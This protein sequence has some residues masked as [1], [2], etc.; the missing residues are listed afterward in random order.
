MYPQRLIEDATVSGFQSLESIKDKIKTFMWETTY[1]D[2]F[3]DWSNR[4]HPVTG[5]EI[6]RIK[7]FKYIIEVY[8]TDEPATY[9]VSIHTP[10]VTI[11]YGGSLW[12]N[13][14][15]CFDELLH[16]LSQYVDKPIQ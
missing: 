14:E 10:T 9:D 6:H 16:Y 7:V 13:Y 12:N 1:H 15:A 3:E 8:A 5:V 11:R 4:L 2:G